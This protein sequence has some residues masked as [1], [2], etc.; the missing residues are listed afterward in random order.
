ML[1]IRKIG[2]HDR[3]LEIKGRP[4]DVRVFRSFRDGFDQKELNCVL[5]PRGSCPCYFKYKG[6]GFC[7][8]ELSDQ[9]CQAE[10]A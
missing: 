9:G 6:F 4:K 2:W 1:A 5:D 10:K 7:V 3:I 8:S